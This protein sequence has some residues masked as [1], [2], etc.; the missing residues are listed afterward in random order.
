MLFVVWCFFLLMLF[1]EYFCSGM[2]E[3]KTRLW[4]I[5][6]THINTLLT[7]CWPY[8][9]FIKAFESHFQLY[10]YIWKSSRDRTW[11]KNQKLNLKVCCSIKIKIRIVRCGNRCI[12]TCIWLCFRRRESLAHYLLEIQELKK[13]PRAIENGKLKFFGLRYKLEYPNAQKIIFWSIKYWR[14]WSNFVHEL[15]EDHV[16]LLVLENGQFYFYFYIQT[17]VLDILFSLWLLQLIL[18]N[19]ES[20]FSPLFPTALRSLRSFDI[21]TFLSLSNCTYSRI[22]LRNKDWDM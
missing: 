5:F 11:C 18:K 6:S 16:N 13:D 3:I 8:V 2:P 17:T 22:A 21:A 4:F 12:F 15:L 20:D 19:H 7:L 10:V 14:K 9:D 1:W